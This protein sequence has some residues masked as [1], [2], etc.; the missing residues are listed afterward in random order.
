MDDTRCALLSPRGIT[1]S[2]DLIHPDLTTHRLSFHAYLPPPSLIDSSTN[3][4][5]GGGVLIKAGPV[6][7]HRPSKGGIRR[8]PKRVWFELG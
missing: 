6:I 3:L 4:T 5:S 7:V 2:F 1:R 8:K